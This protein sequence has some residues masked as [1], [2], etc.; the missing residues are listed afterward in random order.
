MR[1]RFKKIILG[2]FFVL[3]ASMF[4]VYSD[5]YVIGKINCFDANHIIKMNFKYDDEEKV[6]YINRTDEYGKTYWFTVTNDQINTIR[7]SLG[8]C[9]EWIKIAKENQVDVSKELPNSKLSVPGAMKWSDDFYVSLYNL[10]L[11]FYF[12]AVNGTSVLAI[13]GNKVRSSANQFIDLKWND[14]MLIESDVD[15][16]IDVISQENIDAEI[17]KHDEK[18]KDSDDLFN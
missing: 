1:P 7:Q 5:E 10:S 15:I 3:I 8:K 6:F 9:K 12:V 16:F 2:L 13:K 4:N 14:V 18:K 17:K 11:E